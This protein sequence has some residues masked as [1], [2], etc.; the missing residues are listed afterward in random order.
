MNKGRDHYFF[1][2]TPLFFRF[3]LIFLSFASH[4]FSLSP[5]ACLPTHPLHSTLHSSNHHT[6]AIAQICNAKQPKKTLHDVHYTERRL[7]GEEATRI[8]D[9]TEMRLYG[10]GRGTHKE[11]IYTKREHTRREDKHGK[12]IIGRGDYTERRLYK[13]KKT[14]TK[15]RLNRKGATQR[16]ERGHMRRGDYKEKGKGTHTGTGIYGERTNTEKGLIRKAA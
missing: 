6:A 13:G 4:S 9:Y 15:K 5:A 12:E 11:G 3:S 14:N 2:A 10:E 1:C 8:E 16:G 7:Q